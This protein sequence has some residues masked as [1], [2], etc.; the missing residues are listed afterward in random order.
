MKDVLENEIR[1]TLHRRAATLPAEAAERITRVDYGVVA[2]PDRNSRRIRHPQP[3]LLSLRTS[4]GATAT[5]LA[6][7]APAAVILLGSGTPTAYA[8][9]SPVPTTP[10]PAAIRAAHGACAR[11]HPGALAAKAFDASPVL[12]DARGR[13]TALI[14]VAGRVVSVCISSGG[15]RGTGMGG[16]NFSRYAAP[17]PSQLGLPSGGG[18]GAPGFG[19]SGGE[20]HFLGRAGRNISG[21]RFV[22]GSGTT[23]E[24]TVQN[25]W[26]FAWWPSNRR[27]TPSAS[28]PHLQASDPVSV[29]L[30]TNSG[31]TRTSPLMGRICHPGHSGCIFAGLKPFQRPLR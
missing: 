13:Y 11:L 9:W 2:E 1:R 22:L 14:S 3:R 16:E 20:E 18:G 31:V 4:I 5:A 29:Q 7:G 12:T 10:T 26:Y 6:A 19:S 23:V 24:A 30:T 21:V 28:N 27:H 8:G 17:G 25:G 15:R